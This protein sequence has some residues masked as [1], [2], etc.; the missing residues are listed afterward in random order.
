MAFIFGRVI[1]YFIYVSDRNAFEDD[2]DS[3]SVNSFELEEEILKALLNGVSKTAPLK[4]VET[5]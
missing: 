4:I 5:K 1:I 3:N 2:T